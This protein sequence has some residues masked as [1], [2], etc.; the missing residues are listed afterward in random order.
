L[1]LAPCRLFIVCSGWQAQDR[2]IN[3]EL[4]MNSLRH[5]RIFAAAALTLGA[6][7]AASAQP[8]YFQREPVDSQAPTYV[9]GERGYRYQREDERDRREAEWHERQWQRQQHQWQQQEQQQEW[10]PR[11]HWQHAHAQPWVPGRVYVAGSIVQYAGRLYVA[12]MWNNGSL[13]TPN[14]WGWSDWAPYGS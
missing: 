13:P 6:L 3:K 1:V 11:Q 8:I 10:Q 2:F 9:Q 12:K 5:T 14:R 7:G 4:S